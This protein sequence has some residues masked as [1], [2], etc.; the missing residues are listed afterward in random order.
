MTDK[1]FLSSNISDFSLFFVKKLH[2]P[3]LWKNLPL[4]QQPPLKIEIMSSL[5][6]N[7]LYRCSHCYCDCHPIKFFFFIMLPPCWR[8][9]LGVLGL[10]FC[11][12]LYLYRIVDYV[13]A[14]TNAYMLTW[15]TQ[16]Q[17]FYNLPYLII[18]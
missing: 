6:L 4:Y 1:S 10:C 15:R 13:Q 12:F 5:P 18:F 8:L 17:K 16:N 7:I 2:P 3:P 9:F 14:L 11:V